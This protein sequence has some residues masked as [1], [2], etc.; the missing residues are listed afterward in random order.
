V[1]ALA[2]SIGLLIVVL[3]CPAMAQSTQWPYPED[4]P[5]IDPVTIGLAG[6]TPADIVRYLMAAGVLE[7]KISPDG[8][9][10]AYTSRVT[11]EPQLWIVSARGGASTQLT[12]GSGI[13]TFYWAPDSAN[14]VVARD[15]DGNE[16]NGYYLLSV[17]GT[18]ER[19]LLPQS[20]AFRQFGMFS[21]DGERFLFSSTERNGR[22]FDIYMANL[23]GGQ[24]RVLYEGEFGFFPA[25]W[26]PSGNIVLVSEVRGED[27]NDVHVLDVS[28]GRLTPLFQPEDASSYSDFAWLPD[29]SG[30]YMATN[31][32][33]EFTGLAFYSLQDKSLSFIYTSNADVDNVAMSSDGRYLVWTTNEEGYSKLH[34]RDLESGQELMT[35]EL[36]LGVYS[37]AFAKSAPVLVLRISGPAIPGD[38]WTW[39]P[40]SQQAS[41]AIRST[42]A[43]LDSDSFVAPEPLQYRAQDGV[44]LHGLLYRPSADYCSEAPPVVVNVHGGPTS[45]SRPD[46][47]PSAQYFANVCVAVFDVNVRGS[48]GYGKTYARLDNQEKRLDSVRDLVDTA[49]FLAG[50]VRLDAG[51]IAVMGGSY[52]GYMVNAVLGAYPEVFDAGISMVGVSD[53]VRALEEA[54]PFL[55]ASDRIE[56]GDIR[57]ERWQEFY[58]HNSPINTADQIKAPMLIEHGANDPRDPATESD[59]VVETIRG[60]GGTVRYMRFPDEG[61]SLRKQENRV[62]FYR[63]VADFLEEHL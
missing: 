32:D 29:G 20:E 39:S 47:N 37:T 18:R 41:H 33:H 34:G 55:K 21:D 45:Q 44:T 59:R 50:D 9:V 58:R 35:P 60:G 5:Q 23:Q 36:P 54:S 42:L 62:A 1:K 24:P 7:A 48:T 52:G 8:Q 13:T 12:F 4:I 22:D 3:A 31:Q 26:Q 46:F 19:V 38:V 16:R 25:S 51:R 57:E 17:D 40:G 30:F 63:A 27:A 56:Y 2:H 53:W 15:A 28:T 14:L 11:G 49:G 10:V 43:G 61:H 6:E